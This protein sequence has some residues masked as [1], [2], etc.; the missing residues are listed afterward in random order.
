MVYTTISKLNR[1]WYLSAVFQSN[2]GC[3]NAR[4]PDVGI[5]YVIKL[6]ELY[7]AN[8]L[9]MAGHSTVTLRWDS[10]ESLLIPIEVLKYIFMCN[11]T[12]YLYNRGQPYHCI[13]KWSWKESSII[14]TL[15][16][17]VQSGKESWKLNGGTV[18][19]Q[20]VVSLGIAHPT[21]V[22]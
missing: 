8:G 10:A 2:V 17:W 19:G 14:F 1:S 11:L 15:G 6:V 22:G 13:R 12:K 9:E 18:S 20:N 5:A 4:L 7:L 3:H 21:W 16:E